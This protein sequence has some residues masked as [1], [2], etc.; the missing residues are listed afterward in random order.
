[1]GSPVGLDVSYEIK[2]RVK[3]DSKS[4][5]LSNGISVVAIY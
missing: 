3:G 2:K 1:M 5:G 4:L